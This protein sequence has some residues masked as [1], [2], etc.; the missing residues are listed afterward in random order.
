MGRVVH[1][2]PLLDF[3]VPSLISDINNLSLSFFFNLTRGLSILLLFSKN[4][5]LFPLIF[6]LNFLY[7]FQNLVVRICVDLILYLISFH[8]SVLMPIQYC[9]DFCNFIISLE[10]SRFSLFFL[11]KIVL[12]FSIQIFLIFIWILESVCQFL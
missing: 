12:L 9:L 7:L 2:I 1:S 11:F 10:I 8:C 3:D 5:L 4:Q 6:P